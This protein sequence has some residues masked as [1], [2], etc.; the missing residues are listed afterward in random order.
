MT[1]HTHRQRKDRVRDTS[2]IFFCRGVSP[3]LWS[4]K[5]PAMRP[6]SLSMPV[7]VT[8]HTPRPAVTAVPESTMFFRSARGA[9]AASTTSHSLET[10]ADSPVMALS[11]HRSPA[12]SM[13]RASAGIWSPASSRIRSP[14]VSPSG[15][16]RS[17][18]PSRMT[19]ANGAESCCKAARAFSALS[20]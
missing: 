10:G 12:L 20:S 18:L 9:S 16:M 6:I 19:R 5:S 1:A 14:G 11:S 4:C 13:S 8:T 15:G 3:P 2:P 17:S 7:A